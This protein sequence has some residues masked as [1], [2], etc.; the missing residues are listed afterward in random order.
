MDD[1]AGPLEGLRVIVDL[2]QALAGPYC[3]MLLAGLGADVVKVE[4][5]TAT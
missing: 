4:P 5:P 1:A 2:T 3:T